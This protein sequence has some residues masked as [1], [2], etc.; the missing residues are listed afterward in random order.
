MDVSMKSLKSE[1][2]VPSVFALITGPE[3]STNEIR[4]R[5][6]VVDSDDVLISDDGCMFHAEKLYLGSAKKS[7]PKAPSFKL[8]LD[9]SSCLFNNV[10]NST[11]AVV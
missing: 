3:S 11:N 5:R 7:D 4:V 9:E 8:D 2:N 6:D 1:N 10:S